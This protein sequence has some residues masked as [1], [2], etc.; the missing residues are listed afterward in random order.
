MPDGAPRDEQDVSPVP[1]LAVSGDGSRFATRIGA[2]EI[3]LFSLAT[4]R[5]THAFAADVGGKVSAVAWSPPLGDRL[6]VAGKGGRIQLWDVQA[7]PR[8][9]RSLAVLQPDTSTLNAVAFSPDGRTVAAV[10]VDFP[11]KRTG[12]RSEAG[13]RLA[14][15]DRQAPLATRRG[16][17]GRPDVGILA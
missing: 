7:R 16:T 8:L 3:G 2:Q 15:G 13:G 4:L 12:C 10:A 11:R 6:A 14:G 9:V 1:P 17:A 5:R